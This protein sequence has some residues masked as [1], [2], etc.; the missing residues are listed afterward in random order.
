MT[1]RLASIAS[2]F[3]NASPAG[4]SQ[5]EARCPAHDDRTASLSIGEPDN[6]GK[7]L[8]HCHAG[9][10]TAD[11]I[12]HV[13]L[14]IRD[15]FP[16]ADEHH[17]H[18]GH[19]QN[20]NGH[21]K[22]KRGEFDCAYDYRDEAG[23]LV[24]QAVRFKNPKGFA[25]RQPKD[26]GGWNYR[27]KGLRKLVY[28]LPQLLKADSAEPVLIAEGEK[29]CENLAVRG[30]IATCNAMGAG[31]WHSAHSDFL[32]GRHVIV[33]PD[34]DEPGRGHAQQVAK[35]LQGKSASTRILELAGLPDH[36]DVSDWLA[37]GGTAEQLRA[38]AAAA[39][40]WQ[41]S[42]PSE[43]RLRSHGHDASEVTNGYPDTDDD[44]KK[45]VVPLEM[46]EV[47]RRIRAA[48]GDWPRRVDGS[49]FIDDSLGVSWIESAAGLFG[50][51]QAR[52][53]TIHWHKTLGC[54]GREEVFAELR[55]TS[56]R[57][58]AVEEMP[59]EPPLV[60][61][62]Y[63]C[64]TPE[65]GNGEAIRSLIDRFEPATVI[66]RDLIEAALMTVA[67]GGH[68]GT[69]PC[70]VITSDDGRGAGKSKLAEMIGHVAGGI[71]SFSNNEDIGVIK[72][73]LLSPAA[74]TKRVVL[75]DNVKSLKFSWAEF[76]AL[77][78]SPVVSGK[79]MYVGE[80]SRPNTITWFVTLNGASLSTDMAQ[81]SV[82]IKVKRPNR[83]GSW[84]EDTLRFILDNRR[85]LIADLIGCLRR[86]AAQLE[87]F[88]RWATWEKAVLSR[89]AEPTEAQA[90]ITDRQGAVDVDADEAEHME[91]Y[92]A[93]QLRGLGYDPNAERVFI[94]SM[95]A[96]RWLN[97]A[98]NENHR[99]I[100]AGRIISQLCTECRFR[101]LRPNKH[102][103]WGRGLV[104]EP[105][106]ADMNATVWTDMERRL[107]ERKAE[108]AG[109]NGQF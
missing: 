97:W 3:E 70:F 95:V 53:G 41:P 42:E 105:T 101:C 38:L 109:A 78:T 12:A 27:T 52:V 67:W 73:R 93:G 60:G 11:V 26:G 35:S 85:L 43:G 19:S 75:L 100:A 31:K 66:D 56:Q 4:A 59:H 49:L 58:V 69:R 25:Q 72:T 20:G 37:A 23:R 107:A 34:N 90:V 39:T 61:H 24:F 81:R 45:I 92:F 89:L 87:K 88:T 46:T 51:L 15:L 14:E 6:D 103:G 84:E 83:A 96:A 62:Y 21:A 79:Q 65:P 13:G 86:P 2:R 5:W 74:L 36:G 91:E 17:G 57:Y 9:C 104:W 30:F 102:K 44:D 54:V 28:R 22:K 99:T 40:E 106:E 68:G 77:I 98:T 50:W 82:I 18:N 16:D 32:K 80:G 63:A 76:E 47:L 33:L 1:Q 48:T 29:D 64:Q 71:M 55:R 108:R 7:I 94:P 8:I 10:S